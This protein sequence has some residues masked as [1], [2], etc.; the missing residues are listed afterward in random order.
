MGIGKATNQPVREMDWVLG[1]LCLDK[2][3]SL[4]GEHGSKEH[5]MLTKFVRS[6]IPGCLL[7][8]NTWPSFPCAGLLGKSSAV[9]AGGT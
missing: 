7:D 4:T 2:E 5:S 9:A 1:L 3:V 6:H 8:S